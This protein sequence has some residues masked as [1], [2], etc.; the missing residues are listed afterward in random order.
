MYKHSCI[1][2]SNAETLKY[3]DYYTNTQKYK[4][5]TLQTCKMYNHTT[6]HRKHTIK[7]QYKHIKCT[8]TQ[9]TR[10]QLYK[11]TNCANTILQANKCI[12]I[13]NVQTTV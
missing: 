10:K 11:H 8:S 9:L 2:T 4:Q 7:Q 12:N 3:T 5:T 6:V 1:N 13:Q